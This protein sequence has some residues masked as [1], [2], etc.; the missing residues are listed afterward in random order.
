MANFVVH[1]HTA[2]RRHFDL[3]LIEAERIRSWSLLKEPPTHKGEKRLAVE[4]ESMSAEQ[5]SRPIIEEES[6]GAGRALVWDQGMVSIAAVLPGRLVLN[7]QGEK[8]C[9]RYELRRM[10]WYPGNRWLLEKSDP[11]DANL[12]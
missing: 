9:G 4:R 10:R 2:G 3:R 11:A 7:F 8:L 1:R 12:T 5:I 6:F